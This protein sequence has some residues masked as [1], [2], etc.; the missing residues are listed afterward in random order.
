VHLGDDHSDGVCV[1]Y[2]EAIEGRTERRFYANPSEL[3][4]ISAVT[5]RPEDTWVI[6]VP[7]LPMFYL[8]GAV[9]GIRNEDDARRI[10]GHI[11]DAEPGATFTVNITRLAD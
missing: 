9:Q 4:A 5:L 3:S 8:N 10:V 7:G 6:E 1:E 2:I 11:I